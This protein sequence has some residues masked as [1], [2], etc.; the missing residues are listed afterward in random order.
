[1]APRHRRRRLREFSR[2]AS[3]ALHEPELAFR[4]LVARFV[5]QHKD[6]EVARRHGRRGRLKQVYEQDLEVVLE[7]CIALGYML[8]ES[9]AAAL[10]DGRLGRESM[11]ELVLGRRDE[12]PATTY[13]HLVDWLATR[14]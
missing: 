12:P 4:K 7:V 6:H 8:G 10:R 13:F 2:D 11:R 3:R 9:L 1:V 14:A 5:V